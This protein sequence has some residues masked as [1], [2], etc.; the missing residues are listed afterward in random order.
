MLTESAASSV[1]AEKW[2]ETAL[3]QS[4]SEGL[5]GCSRSQRGRCAWSWLASAALVSAATAAA[6]TLAY[7]A[8]FPEEDSPCETAVCVREVARLTAS[9]DGHAHPCRHLTAF[10]CGGTAR[11]G[12]LL[13]EVH[14]GNL[15]RLNATLHA[16]AVGKSPFEAPRALRELSGLYA[17]CY[18]AHFVERDLHDALYAFLQDVGV[19][20]RA[21]LRGPAENLLA[22]AASL[23]LQRAI[24]SV[25]WLRQNPASGLLSVE[26]ARPLFSLL[27][28]CTGHDERQ[29]LTQ[30]VVGA[31]DEV[32]DNV[33]ELAHELAHTHA[34]LTT[35]FVP[36]DEVVPL[37]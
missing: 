8:L 29:Q 10:V 15:G 9:L 30:Q 4:S 6:L 35:K 31:I 1:C 34:V 5:S 19:S 17:S 22:Q 2:T 16:T 33:D 26:P 36:R 13:A 18:T 21:W 28:E 37:T 24:P 11:S 25:L 23:S 14:A 32:T 3:P 7:Q 12:S 27:P 20:V